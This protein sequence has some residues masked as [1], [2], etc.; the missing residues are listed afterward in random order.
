MMVIAIVEKL[1]ANRDGISTTTRQCE[2]VAM[3]MQMYYWTYMADSTPEEQAAT[4]LRFSDNVFNASTVS[5]L[6]LCP[7]LLRHLLPFC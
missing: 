5:L 2:A 1:C 4:P 3:M 6:H 7:K